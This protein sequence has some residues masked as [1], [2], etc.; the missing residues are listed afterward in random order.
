MFA[1][2]SDAKLRI[3]LDRLPITGEN[4]SIFFFYI[5]TKKSGFNCLFPRL[6]TLELLFPIFNVSK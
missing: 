2:L 4:I 5:Q 1:R 3:F 6:K